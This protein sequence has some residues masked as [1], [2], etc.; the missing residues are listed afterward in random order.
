MENIL[1][2]EVEIDYSANYS[3]IRFTVI[4]NTITH[5]VDDDMDISLDFP[6]TDPS[7]S[8]ALK[9]MSAMCFLYGRSIFDETGVP[10]GLVASDWGGTP[11]ESWTNDE[12][13][14]TCNVPAGPEPCTICDDEACECEMYCY[15]VLL[16]IE[17]CS[18]V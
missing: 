1:N 12:V 10:Q 14:D 3:Q 16:S 8:D 7:W 9:Q 13:L 2:S 6:W 17:S 5:E 4:H 15:S 11:I 18:Q